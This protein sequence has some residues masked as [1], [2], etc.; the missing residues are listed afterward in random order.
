MT[1]EPC[2]LERWFASQGTRSPRDLSASGAPPITLRDLL[3]LASAAERE[4]FMGV[5]LGYGPP[6]GSAA[7]RALVAVRAGVPPEHVLITCG[8]IEALHLAMH[9]LVGPGDEVIVQQPMYPAVAGLARMRGALVR[10]WPLARRN[11]AVAR[12]DSLTGLLTHATRIVAITQP[13]G[14]TGDVLDEDELEQMARL[15]A[16]RGILLLADEVYRDLAIEPG[17]TVASAARDSNA[18][19]VGDVAKPFGLGGLRVG[20][21]IA[22]DADLRDRVGTLRDYSTLSV[23]TAS[24]ALAQIALRHVDDLLRVPLRNIRANLARLR[25]FAERDHLVAFDAPRA[26]ATAFVRVADAD[27]MQRALAGA[28]VLVVPGALFGEPDYL[29][30]G[31]AGAEDEFADALATLGRTLLDGGPASRP[32][33]MTAMT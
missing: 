11:E 15:L 13:N 28:G 23:P 31:L 16:S 25:A 9:S 27:Q 32:T 30:M 17:L 1:I 33:S 24:D 22:R 10:H 26:G 12:I 4:E 21:L 29:R 5:S 3:G 2:A 6:A 14:P 7:L 20:W 19:V 8:A 18:I